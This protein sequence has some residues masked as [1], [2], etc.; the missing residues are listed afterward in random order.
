MKA[1]RETTIF[2]LHFLAGS[3]GHARPEVSEG[4]PGESASAEA[5]AAPSKE[6]GLVTEAEA[7]EEAHEGEEEEGEGEGD[8]TID[9]PPDIE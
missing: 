1:N 7:E 4:Q 3:A 9:L 6:L 2:D 8:E 5:S